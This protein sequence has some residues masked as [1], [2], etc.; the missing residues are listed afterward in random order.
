MTQSQCYGRLLRGAGVGAQEGPQRHMLP[1]IKPI[2]EIKL[3]HNLEPCYLFWGIL[4]AM[5][6]LLS[7]FV[8]NPFELSRL[9]PL[10]G[11]RERT[12]WGL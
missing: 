9:G 10:S 5:P 11:R 1:A 2:Q 8:L 7:Y 6:S 4:L 12:V 3:L